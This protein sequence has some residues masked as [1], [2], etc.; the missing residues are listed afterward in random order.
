MGSKKRLD[1]KN[2]CRV[3]NRELKDPFY[4]GHGI[5]KKCAQKMGLL[6]SVTTTTSKTKIKE[7]GKVKSKK[8]TLRLRR[9][10]SYKRDFDNPT[11]MKI[12]YNYE[13]MLI[14]K[15]VTHE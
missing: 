14:A 3:C 5:G 1:N 9:T 11:Q 12:P 4:V 10:R 8:L 6:I 15:P 2:R 7:S 13:E